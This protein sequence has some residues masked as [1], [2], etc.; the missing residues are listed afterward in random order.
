M[1]NVSTIALLD[2]IKM[3]P[4]VNALLVIQPA[5]AVTMTQGT[6]ALA[7]VT[8]APLNITS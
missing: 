6:I 4:I 7:V 3:S 1:D 2:T 8:S 5:S